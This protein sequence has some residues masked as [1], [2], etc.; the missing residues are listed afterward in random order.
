MKRIGISESNPF[1][2]PLQMIHGDTNSGV[3]GYVRWGKRHPNPALILVNLSPQ[4]MAIHHKYQI[5][6]S[7]GGWSNILNPKSI[8]MG[9][10]YG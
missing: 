9:Q 6:L 8:K 10:L 7:A 5:N 3:A 2:G 1:G 4:Q